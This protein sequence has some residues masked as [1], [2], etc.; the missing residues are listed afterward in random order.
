MYCIRGG[1]THRREEK[2]SEMG[3]GKAAHKLFRTLNLTIQGIQLRL[4][5]FL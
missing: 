4:T 2:D 5:Q 1:D 3:T